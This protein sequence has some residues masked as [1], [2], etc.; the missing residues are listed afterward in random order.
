MLEQNFPG[1]YRA[2][3]GGHLRTEHNALIKLRGI[4]CRSYRRASGGL[5]DSLHQRRRGAGDEVRVAAIHRRDGV[6]SQAQR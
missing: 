1:R 4:W 6:S 5:D 3:G 2:G